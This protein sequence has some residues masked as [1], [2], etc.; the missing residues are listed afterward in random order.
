MLLFWL[1]YI[2]GFA[3]QSEDEERQWMLRLQDGDKKALQLL[4]DKYNK[5]LFGLIISILKD[6][7]EAEDCLQEVFTQLW[8]KAEQYDASRGKVYSF[9]VTM[10]RNKAIDRTRSR[11]FKDSEK[12]DHII[13]DFTMTPESDKNNP[14]ED[15]ELSERASLVRQALQKLSDKE[16]KVLQVA[17]F[18]GLSQSQISNKL[19]IPLGTVKYRMRQGM[20]KLRENLIPDGLR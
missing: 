6:R 2:V 9:L 5:I 4:Y 10:A 8:E 1:I 19:D 12:E 17:Y 13:S 11:G 18:Q 7:E 15:L 16:Q 20:I 14:Y 3:V